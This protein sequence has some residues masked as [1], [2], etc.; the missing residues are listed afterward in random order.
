[1][2]SSRSI[3][4]WLIGSSFSFRA[5]SR[6]RFWRSAA[7]NRAKRFFS[8]SRFL[9]NLFLVQEHVIEIMLPQ[10]GIGYIIKHNGEC[11]RLNFFLVI[12]ATLLFSL[13]APELEAHVTPP[14]ESGGHN[15][16]QMALQSAH[17]GMKCSSPCCADNADSA[18]AG[19]ELFESAQGCCMG[20]LCGYVY[21]DHLA[22]LFSL[23]WSTPPIGPIETFIIVRSLESL[24]TVS[25]ENG[26]SPPARASTPQYL[27]NCSFL[28]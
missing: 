9:I 21:N 2:I 13:T 6:F 3:S 19:D 20:K 28:I 8:H 1:M 22:V 10:C 4:G 26:R 27:A 14:P 15:C 12:C 16:K 11:M 7:S 23:S 5:N 25:A 17:V 18:R 24:S